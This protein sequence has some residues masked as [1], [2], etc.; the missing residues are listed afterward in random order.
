MVR[1]VDI[2]VLPMGSQSPSAPSVFLLNLPLGKIVGSEYLHLYWSSAGRASQGIAIPGFC[3]QALLVIINRVVIWCLHVGWN[4]RWGGLWM[5]FPSVS[6]P[7]FVSA[8]LLDRKDYGLNFLR[9]LDG[10]ITPLGAV[11]FY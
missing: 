9:W 4:P 1:L 5:T 7:V 3:Q 8:L 6:A 10:L 2:V 11:P